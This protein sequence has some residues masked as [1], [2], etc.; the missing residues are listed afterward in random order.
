MNIAYGIMIGNSG[1]YDIPGNLVVSPSASYW[2]KQSAWTA[3]IGLVGEIA[4][5]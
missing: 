3:V 5:E 4:W 1:D 2:T